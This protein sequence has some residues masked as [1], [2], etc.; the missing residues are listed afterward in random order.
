[1]V[2]VLFTTRLNNKKFLIVISIVIVALI[3]DVSI[4][5]I[6]LISGKSILSWTIVIFLVIATVYAIGQ[7]LVLEFVK[8]K[9]KEIRTKKQL[10]LNTIHKVITIVQYILTA[11]IIFVVLQ[12]L[13]TS[14][15]NTF[16]LTAS[17]VMSYI[18]AITMLGLLAQRFFLWFRSN[19]NSIVILYG[20]SSAILAINAIFTLIFVGTISFSWPKV[21][22]PFFLGGAFLPPGSVIDA[23]NQV[24]F[25]SSIVAFTITWLSTTL[26]LRHY[27]QRVGRLKYWIIL[28]IPLA[29]FL[30]QFVTL[31]LN[32]FA[33][34]LKSDPVFFGILLTLIFTLTKPVG[35]ILFGIALWTLAKNISHG[36]IVRDYIVISAYGFILLFISEQAIVLLSYPPFGL[37]TNSFVG[38]SSYLILVGI[39]SSAISIGEDMKLRQSIRKYALKESKLLD[40]IGTAQLEQEIQRRVV[41]MTREHEDRIKE[42]IGLQ[43]SLNED[44]IKQYVDEVLK[45]IK[46]NR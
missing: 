26:L 23:L 36:S 39:Y 19:R 38:L 25:I 9:S 5:R 33:P 34:L 37:V 16:M 6:Y 3:I 4:I 7:Y 43:S 8:Q 22:H 17:T 27:I 30:S 14:S 41:I 18:V 46:S 29:F 32:L 12:I 21:I 20:L 28:G 42:E 2:H 31:S 35:G 11:I 45:E 13:M 44:D 15:Y 10:H 24:V 1:M 40:S